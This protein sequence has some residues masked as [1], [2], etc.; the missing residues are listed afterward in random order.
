M[1][2]DLLIPKEVMPTRATP[3]PAS[4]LDLDPEFFQTNFNRTPYLVR[5]NLVGHSLFTLP[6]LI[7]LAQHMPTEFVEYY[8]GD[9]PVNVDWELTPRNG[10]SVEETIR[11]IEGHCSWMVLKRVEQDAEYNELL[12]TILDQIE[13]LS[14]PL[15]PGMRQ[16]AGAV[17]ISSP[18]AVTPYH[19]DQEY[20]FLFQLRGNKTMY[21]FDGN[22]RSLLTE[23]ELEN[24]FR[25]TT[26]D[27]NLVFRDEYTA[28]GKAFELTPGYALHVPSLYPH[29]VKNGSS[30]SISFSAGFDTFS[31]VR[32]GSLYRVN[33]L[34][35]TC[36][37]RP[38]PVGESPMRDWLKFT[39]YRGCDR[40]RRMWSGRS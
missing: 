26:I 10:L 37:L 3:A 14:S 39:A 17:F 4:A 29:W 23:Q 27:R 15:D 19:M 2:P 22:D 24:H 1:A 18:G 33:Q 16:R 35:R 11:R 34:L 32:K 8:A 21:V 7:R 25:H 31:S 40:V 36:G 20:N 28:K 38:T 9:V 13:P 30:V 12:N 5:H 6:R